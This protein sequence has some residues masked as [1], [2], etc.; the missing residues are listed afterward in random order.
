M[1]TKIIIT[2]I[3]LLCF[4][5]NSNTGSKTNVEYVKEIGFSYYPGIKFVLND[6]FENETLVPLVGRD[7]F[8]DIIF[9]LPTIVHESFHEFFK[10]E[11]KKKIGFFHYYINDS[12][13]I[14]VKFFDMPRVVNADVLLPKQVTQQINEYE[15]YILETFRMPDGKV[16]TLESIRNFKF[17]HLFEEY[18]CQYHAAKM[19]LNL[20]KYT[21][22][23]F[24]N[25]P[26]KFNAEILW[27]ASS[28]NV[29]C[30]VIMTRYK[31]LL[32]I[33]LAYLNE[34]EPK[35]FKQIIH[36]EEFKAAYTFLNNE[37]KK[38][39]L[40]L[41][42]NLNSILQKNKEYIKITNDDFL[43]VKKRGKL[44]GMNNKYT[45]MIDN[46]LNNPRLKVIDSLLIK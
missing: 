2:L 12:L 18:V 40:K 37:D 26:S 43:W 3:L 23:S 6:I 22:D 14:W 8:P 36:N 9:N 29:Y 38:I 17:F 34:N 31:L 27:L 24:P 45:L 35:Y 13:K 20:Y 4:S 16:D 30:E 7:T 1:G 21:Q 15:T 19:Y 41:K 25:Q 11:R 39:R 28:N 10:S 46:L 5:F 32:A 42:Q 44:V 33:Y